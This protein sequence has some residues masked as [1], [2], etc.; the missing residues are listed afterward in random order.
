VLYGAYTLYNFA[1]GHLYRFSATGQFMAA[2]DFGWDTTPAIYQHG[3]TFSVVLK[4]TTTTPVRI[5]AI[6]TSVQLR[7]QDRTTSPN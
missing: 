1:R 3:S 5:A 6:L 7:L 2:Y 4:A